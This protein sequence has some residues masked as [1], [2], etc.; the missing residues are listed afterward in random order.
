MD[1]LLG[2]DLARDVGRTPAAGLP[3]GAQD[4]LHRRAAARADQDYAG[5]DALR[6]ALAGLGVHVADTPAGQTW[7][8][9]D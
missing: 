7:T 6:D 1:A 3:A 5:A 2:L 9:A 8:V 4:L